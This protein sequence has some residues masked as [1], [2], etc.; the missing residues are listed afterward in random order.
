LPEGHELIAGTRTEDIHQYYKLS[1]VSIVANSHCIKLIVHIPLKSADHFTLYKIIILPERISSDKF[2]QYAIDC[3]YLVIQVSQHDYIPF[4]E[5]DYSKCVTSSITVCPLDSAI[6][7]T[8]LCK[9]N[10]LL[11][12]QQSTMIHRNIWIYHFPTPRQLTLRCPGN[13]ASPAR[14]QVLVNAGMLFNASACHVSTE[15]LRMY[16]TLRG[17]KQAELN[18]PHIFLLDK[19]PIISQHESHQIQELTM[20]KLQ[21]LENL[22]SHLPIPLHSLDVDSLLH[23]HQTTKI[24][25]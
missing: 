8:Q 9:K 18:R 17:S 13:E 1:K 23:M 25:N 19:V 10:L 16:P 11:N 12:C 14:T 7:N 15:D 21:A 2:V 22:R 20:P 24:T 5:K 3:P 6:V 4:T